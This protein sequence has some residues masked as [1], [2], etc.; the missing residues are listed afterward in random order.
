MIALDSMTALSD[1]A[2][3][4]KKGAPIPPSIWEH[5]EIMGDYFRYPP[6]ER[7]LPQFLNRTPRW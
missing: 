4:Y 5:A 7:W 3:D 1:F 6:A 2:R